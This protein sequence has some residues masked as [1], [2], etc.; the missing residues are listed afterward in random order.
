M[1]RSV[2]RFATNIEKAKSLFYYSKDISGALNELDPQTNDV[3]TLKQ[4][5]W[6]IQFASSS[7]RNEIPYIFS[8]LSNEKDNP[9]NHLSWKQMQHEYLIIA[10][11]Q[12]RAQKLR[13]S[14]RDKN[15]EESELR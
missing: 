4:R 9:K 15:S 7:Y 8:Q 10:A 2:A 12:E 11:E 13:E 5:Y 3:N 1:R 6:L 14:F